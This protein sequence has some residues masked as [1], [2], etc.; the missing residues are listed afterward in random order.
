MKKAVDFTFN[1]P[2]EKG[3]RLS[4]EVKK[5]RYTFLIFLRYF[6]CTSCQ[7]D[8]RD[9]SDAY[10]EFKEKGAQILA[11]LQSSPEILQ[12]G[13]DERGIP[14]K[15]ISDPE[16]KL[17]P[18]YEVRAAEGYEGMRKGMTEELAKRFAEKAERGKSYGYTHG[19]YEGNEFQLPAYFLIDSE[20]NLLKEH[21]ADNMAD[22][23]MG[24]EYLELI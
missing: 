11:V 19:E 4:D 7:I 10:E 3:L 13:I 15:L 16:Q 24:R 5:S 9:L 14:F 6:G 8:L 12:K 21:R 22:M 20:M 17:Y 2:S 18:L 23:P 1:T